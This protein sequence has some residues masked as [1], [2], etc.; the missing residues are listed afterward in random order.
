MGKEEIVRKKYLVL[1]TGGNKLYVDTKT[2]KEMQRK[3]TIVCV[4]QYADDDL[5]A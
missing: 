3:R 4:Y 2:L 5:A 1:S